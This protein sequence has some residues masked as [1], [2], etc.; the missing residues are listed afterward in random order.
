MRAAVLMA[1]AFALSAVAAG[2]GGRTAAEPLLP[3]QPPRPDRTTVVF[4]GDSL[5]AGHGVGAERAFPAVMQQY[6]GRRGVPWTAVNE[7]IS[8]DTTADVLRRLGAS[9]APMAELT[10]LE[11]GANDAFQHAP[12]DTIAANVR[13]IIRTVRAGGSRV[14]LS[15]M[16]FSPGMLGGDADYTRRFNALYADVGRTEKVPVLPPLLRS[17][18]ERSDI[19]LP[20]GLHPTEEGH[21][22]IARDLLGDL[23]PDWR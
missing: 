13:Q 18:F 10:V 21:A 3:A 15:T 9:R 11:I 7:G 20:D 23:N 5:T 8:G 2:A 6:W 22:L 16:A 14:V 19:W 17:L 1:A 4:L 12:V